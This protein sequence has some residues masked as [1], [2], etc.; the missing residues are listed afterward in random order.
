MK[1]LAR[2]R[3]TPPRRDPTH[4]RKQNRR[5]TAMAAIRMDGKALAAKV[6]EQTR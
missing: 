4:K 3:I 5:M 6:K 2:L 1:G